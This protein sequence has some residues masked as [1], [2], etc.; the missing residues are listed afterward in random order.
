MQQQQ[1]HLAAILFTDI[2]GYTAMMQKD[3]LEAMAV[4]RQYTSVLEKLVAE[5]NGEVVN[6]YGDGSL[7]TFNS[8]TEAIKCAV[9]IQ[10]QLQKK[11][12]VPL[13]IGLHIGEIFFEN[14]KVFGDG[15]N[16]ASRIQS[17]GQA[18]TILFS[19]EINNKIKNQQEFKSVSLGRFEFKNVDEPVEVFALANEGLVVPKKAEMTGKLKEAGK[20]FSAKKIILA[21]GV[22]ALIIV[23]LLAGKKFFG[24]K[25]P[26]GKDKTIAVL[27][28]KNISINKEENE[29][30]CDG[31]ALELQRKLEW[32]GGLIPIASQSVEKYRDTR[33]T[34]ADIAKELGGISYILNGSVQRDKNKI[35]VFASLID[36]LT[37]KEIWSDDYPGEVEDIF[38]LQEDIAQQIASALQVKITPDEQSRISRV[39][40]KSAVAIDAYNEALTSYVKLATAVHPLFWDSLPSNPRLYGEYLKTLSLCDNAVNTDPSMAEAYV[41]KGQTYLYSTKDWYASKAKRVLISDSVKLLANKALQIDRYSADAYLLISRCSNS[42]DSSLAYLEKAI[43]INPNNFDVNRALGSYY[44]VR[45]PEKAVRFSK[46]AI[47]LNPLSVWTPLVYGD[48]GFTYHNFGDFEKAEL[49]GKKAI[50]LSVNSMIA[51]EAIRRLTITYLHWGKADSVIKYANQ[52]LNQD[53]SRETNALYEIAEAYCNLKNDC[54]MATQLYEELWTRYGNHSNLHRWAVALMQSGKSKEGK[55]KLE[56]AIKEYNEKQ[57]TLSYDYA[58]ICAL[59]GDKEKAMKILRKWDWQWGSPYLIQH[60]KL[61]DNIRNEKEFKEILQKALDEKTKLREKIRKLEERGD[62]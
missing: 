55:E 13:R 48:L 15:V 39:A 31:V 29:P 4:I 30:F 34:I 9:E 51:I 62:L 33:M 3:E 56:L 54:A 53:A 16:L 57:L 44:A 42:E 36:A 8:A 23:A 43:A 60:D 38:S 19:G 1:H 20:K 17:L 40:T 25:E 7:C 11:P 14:G 37:G 2:V 41:L 22:V 58:G 26:A 10:Q 32:L 24:K 50:E 12:P 35:K 61:F 49:Y 52:Y 18:N 45:E 27:P 59:N 47:R 6:N 28:F 5:H 46:K 21:G